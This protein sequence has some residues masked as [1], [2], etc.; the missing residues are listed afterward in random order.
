MYFDKDENGNKESLYTLWEKYNPNICMP[1]PMK[2]Y[3]PYKATPQNL[4]W[5]EY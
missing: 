2:R 5:D 1:E 4:D 3:D